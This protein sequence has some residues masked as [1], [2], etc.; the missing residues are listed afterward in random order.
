MHF[1]VS[2]VR[3][4]EAA[5]DARMRSEMSLGRAVLAAGGDAQALVRVNAGGPY[6]PRALRGVLA[7]EEKVRS[8]C[9]FACCV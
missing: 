8:A 2:D 4:A 6:G 7:E 5:V 1:A 3:A 9:A